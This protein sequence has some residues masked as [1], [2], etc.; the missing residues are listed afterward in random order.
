MSQELL[1]SWPTKTNQIETQTKTT[2]STS[3]SNSNDSSNK[4]EM[5]LEWLEENIKTILN[6]TKNSFSICVFNEHQALSYFDSLDKDERFQY[7]AISLQGSKYESQYENEYEHDSTITHIDDY[8]PWDETKWLHSKLYSTKYNTDTVKSN[9]D[10]A[11]SEQKQQQQQQQ[12]LSTTIDQFAIQIIQQQWKSWI[13]YTCPICY[14]TICYKDD[15]IELPCRHILC[16]TCTE[17]YIQSKFSELHLNRRKLPFICPIT[18]CKQSMK[19]RQHF[20][21]FISEKNRK[22][23][24]EWKFNLQ[25]PKATTLT[26]CPRKAC[27]S[28]DMRYGTNKPNETMVF[29]N[30]CSKGFCEACLNI[31]DGIGWRHYSKHTQHQ[32]EKDTVM[33]LYVLYTHASKEEK[34]KADAKW[35][36]LKDFRFGLDLL[37]DA[38]ILNSGT[39]CPTCKVGIERISGCNHMK[40][41]QCGTHF[42]YAC[43]E[44]ECAC[45][46]RQRRF[47]NL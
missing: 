24:D 39:R 29:C 14:D 1:A 15:G 13:A 31:Y 46:S 19:I 10:P 43:C 37:T 33:K 26:I 40:C 25:F 32:C 44:E 4:E 41:S 5:W 42:C 9:K 35:H 27:K 36:W 22:I 7:I 28:T 2:T 18:S 23:L 20:G 30:T 6:E 11:T 17:M 3:S 34:C 21:P 45:Y 16:T 12:S 47:D 8:V 38:W